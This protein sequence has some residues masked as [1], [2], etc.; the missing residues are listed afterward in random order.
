MKNAV[1]PKK[2]K[3]SPLSLSTFTFL[4]FSTFTFK[5]PTQTFNLI[6]F[7]VS[8]VHATAINSDENQYMYTTLSRMS[9]GNYNLELNGAKEN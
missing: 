5:L 2:R 4:S 6:T 1:R 7:T 3:W 9:N 8:R